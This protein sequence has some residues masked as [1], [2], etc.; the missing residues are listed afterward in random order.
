MYYNKTKNKFQIDVYNV[1]FDT[2]I[3]NLEKRFNISS[4]CMADLACLHYT[5]L[6][7]KKLIFKLKTIRAFIK[8]LEKI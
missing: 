1:I 7:L 3:S 4:K 6:D 2:A 8:L 5:L